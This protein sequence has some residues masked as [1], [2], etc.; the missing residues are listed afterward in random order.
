MFHRQEEFED[1]KEV[2]RSCKWKTNRENNGQST[3]HYTENLR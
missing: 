3:K 1:N 2:I